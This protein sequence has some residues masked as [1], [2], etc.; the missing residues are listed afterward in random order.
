MRNSFLQIN[1]HCNK[2]FKLNGIKKCISNSARII[3]FNMRLNNFLINCIK[4]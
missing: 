1:M 3:F 2:H 4:F